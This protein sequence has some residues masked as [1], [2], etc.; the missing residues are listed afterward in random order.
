VWINGVP[1]AHV[2]AQ[3]MLLVQGLPKG[4]YSLV[5]RTALAERT[6]GPFSVTVPGKLDLGAADPSTK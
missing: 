1:V 4:R 3:R 6:D 5:W 2:A